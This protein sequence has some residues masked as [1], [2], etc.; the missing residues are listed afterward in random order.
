MTARPVS[1]AGIVKIDQ[2]AEKLRQRGVPTPLLRRTYEIFY[3]AGALVMG[4]KFYYVSLARLKNPMSFLGT[5][6]LKSIRAY[7][8]KETTKLINYGGVSCKFY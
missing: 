3:N 7:F 6:I 1:Q 8:G 4:F 5:L 2:L